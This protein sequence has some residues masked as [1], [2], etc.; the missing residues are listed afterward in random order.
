MDELNNDDTMNKTGNRTLIIGG[1]LVVVILLAVVAF[2]FTS[3]GQPLDAGD[4]DQRLH[5]QT[6]GDVE[7]EAKEVLDGGFHSG[8]PGL[9]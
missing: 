5:R 8:R 6:K 9:L 1:V 3:G 7:A 2:M 4:R